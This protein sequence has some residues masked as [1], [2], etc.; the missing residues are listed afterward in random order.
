[1]SLTGKALKHIDSM[2]DDIPGI[3]RRRTQ[4]WFS[5]VQPAPQDDDS[6]SDG[7][8]SQLCRCI[9]GFFNDILGDIEERKGPG[10][11][12]ISE[13]HYRVL[14]N[15]CDN[16]GEWEDR[17]QVGAGGLDDALKDSQDARQFTLRIMIRICETLTNGMIETT[18]S[19]SD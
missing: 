9:Y 17:F 16:F 15:T 7:I 2:Q 19:C 18:L 5:H 14:D 6:R 12:V 1:M 13:Q 4:E 11:E 10:T 8:I 3:R